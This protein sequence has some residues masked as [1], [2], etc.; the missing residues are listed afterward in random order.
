VRFR[1]RKEPE[2]DRKYSTAVELH[3]SNAKVVEER[4]NF[5]RVVL[6]CRATRRVA[7]GEQAVK[8]WV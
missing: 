1:R 7:A 6:L 3:L 4:F 5:T 2:S 8:Q